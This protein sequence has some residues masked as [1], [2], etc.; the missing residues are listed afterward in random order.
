[1]PIR[2]IQYVYA[3][4]IY[5]VLYNPSISYAQGAGLDDEALNS[6]LHFTRLAFG[7]N[8]RPFSSYRGE[9]WLRDWPDAEY[10]FLE[11]VKRLTTIDTGEYRQVSL[12]NDAIFDYPVIYAVKV[13]YWYLST[14]EALRLREYLLKGGL[15]IVDDF[16][17]PSEWAQ[18]IAS[19]RKVFPERAV[20]DIPDEHEIFHVLYDLD[21]R[22]QLPGRNSIY[23]GVTWEHPLGIPEHW[24]G[25][26]DDDGRIMMAINFNMDMGDAWEHADDAFYPEPMTALAYRVGINYIIY[27]MTH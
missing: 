13:G 8:G 22:Q 1:M 18:F 4:L 6:E 17:G 7:V 2:V 5:A 24:R 11:G 10:H 9:A 14:R 27:T 23:N 20:I 25:I 21:D 26:Y 19:V 3:V 12:L 15:L 16:H